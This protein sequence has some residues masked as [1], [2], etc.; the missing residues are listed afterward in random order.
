MNFQYFI[1]F[2][3]YNLKLIITYKINNYS[4]LYN[5]EQIKRYNKNHVVPS[6]D[7]N[8]IYISYIPS[9]NIVNYPYIFRIKI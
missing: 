2:K 4:T 1:N 6:Y 7:F 8:N 9:K 5:F 3:S